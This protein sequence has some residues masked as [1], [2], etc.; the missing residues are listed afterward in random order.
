MVI[1]DKLGAGPMHGKQRFCSLHVHNHPGGR[2]LAKVG[3]ARKNFHAHCA[4][5]VLS[6]PLYKILDTPLPIIFPLPQILY[7]NLQY[8][9][10]PPLQFNSY[11]GNL[12]NAD[13][14]PQSQ[15]IP[16][17]LLYIAI[18]EISLLRITDTKVKPQW[19]KS[20]QMSL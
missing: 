18:A 12:H 20:I 7:K 4:H 8:S 5:R 14:R 6:T 17:G 13:K 15:I 3:V 2:G 10:R 16:Y 9:P 1:R 19:T 11:S